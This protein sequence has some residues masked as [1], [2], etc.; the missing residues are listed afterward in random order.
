MEQR[1]KKQQLT[2]VERHHLQCAANEL[3]NTASKDTVL[4]TLAIYACLSKIKTPST[5]R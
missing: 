3:L 4:S 5:K 2:T 1:V